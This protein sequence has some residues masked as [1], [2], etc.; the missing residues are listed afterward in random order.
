MG[1]HLLCLEIHNTPQLPIW[2]KRFRAPS[3]IH[4]ANLAFFFNQFFKNLAHHEI[5]SH[6]LATSIVH[7]TLSFGE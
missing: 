2:A 7:Y 4:G 6:K 1:T 3:S 5:L